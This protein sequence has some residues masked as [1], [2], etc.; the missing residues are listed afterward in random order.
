MPRSIAKGSGSEV[1]GLTRPR[2][3]RSR[4]PQ[5]RMLDQDPE[6]LA[7]GEKRARK[8]SWMSISRAEKKGEDE[9]DRTS[10]ITSD[11]GKSGDADPGIVQ[12]TSESP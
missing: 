2:L 10:S 9:I 12:G 11:G 3:G 8:E 5:Y 4:N 7:R 1:E 6:G